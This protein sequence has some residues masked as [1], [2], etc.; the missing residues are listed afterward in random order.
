[1]CS[2]LASQAQWRRTTPD[3]EW[4]RFEKSFCLGFDAADLFFPD[5]ALLV[6]ALDGIALLGIR[7]AGCVS[8]RI[9]KMFFAQSRSALLSSVA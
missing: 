6:S 1:M 8:E 3:S 5:A 7:G 9:Q 2:P 4:P